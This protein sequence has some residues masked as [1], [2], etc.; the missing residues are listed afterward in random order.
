MLSRGLQ[1]RDCSPGAYR[2]GA[3]RPG[4]PGPGLLARGLQ[5]GAACPG[6][7]RPGQVNPGLLAWGCSPVASRPWAAHPGL[8][9]QGCL[10]AWLLRDEA[11]P[12][13]GQK[14]VTVSHTASRQ[15]SLSCE[16]YGEGWR[17]GRHRIASS[18]SRGY[19]ASTKSQ[20]IIC[21][22]L[23][24]QQ[25]LPLTSETSGLGRGMRD[26][27]SQTPATTPGP[28]ALSHYHDSPW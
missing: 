6:P 8:L 23:K 20:V 21:L 26:P 2:P 11:S 13:T 18:P 24:S 9:S 5:A 16:I 25:P 19:A 10:L 22:I 3:A 4:H 27:E 28:Q 15:W 1:A 7:P 17:S 14:R 12:C